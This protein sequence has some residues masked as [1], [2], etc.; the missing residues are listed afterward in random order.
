[1]SEF[2]IIETQ[3][4]LDAIISDR[5]SR[6]EKAVRAE[7]AD[8]EEIKSQNET[9]NG[10]ITELTGRVNDLT[11]K[12]NSVDDIQKELNKYKLDSWKTQAAV[13][14]NIPMKLRDRIQGDDEKTIFS[15]A[16]TL[17]PLLAQQT[18][19]QPKKKAEPSG[20]GVSATQQALMN[21]SK[22]LRGE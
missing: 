13:K 17:A 18:P 11:E 9:L 2:K 12:A 22:K 15:D 8:Y 14:Y 10:Q 3:E 4:Q 21:M 16:E 5:L 20:E 1:M 6:K 7:Y 19:K